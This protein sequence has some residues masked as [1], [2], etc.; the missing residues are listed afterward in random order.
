M[1]PSISGKATEEFTPEAL[2][3][4]IPPVIN[5]NIFST[6]SQDDLLFNIP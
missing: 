5:Y 3:F 2:G 1:T 6:A 4:D